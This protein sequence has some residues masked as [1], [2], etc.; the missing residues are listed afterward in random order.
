[1]RFKHEGKKVTLRGINSNNTHCPIIY[2]Q[3]L[4]LLL[5]QGA[6]A[7]LIAL[8]DKADLTTVSV[9]PDSIQKIVEQHKSL[10]QEPTTLPPAR[11][12]DHQ[13]PLIPGAVPVQKK[14][15]RYA[16]T[17][18]DELEKQISEMLQKGVIQQSNSPY[19]S[20]V[21]LVK[22]KDGGWRM[23]VDYR[24]LNA[25]TVKNKYPMPVVDELLDELVGA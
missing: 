20:P 2:A 8:E 15:Y 5:E 3:Q 24:Y 4:N 13:I 19:A 12:F 25:L 22:K 23:C 9:I 18:K 6:V 21:I 14:P 17:Q 1:M 11:E 10:F 16:P 7:Q